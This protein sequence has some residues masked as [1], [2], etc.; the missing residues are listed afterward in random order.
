MAKLLQLR[1][2]TTAQHTSGGGFTGA[3][4][5]VT[6]D[7]TKDTLV[8]HD[9]STAGGHPIA[10]EI[11][12][13]TTVQHSS[14][15]GTVGE[16]TVD[17]DKD[18]LV[19]HD[20]ST[21]GGFPLA[22]FT[23]IT[24]HLAA[25][26]ITSI[27]YPT[28]DGQLATALA[29][30]G[31]DT[32]SETLIITGTGFSSTVT[33]TVEIAGSWYSLAGSTS[34]NG[35]KTVITCTNVTQ[36]AAGDNNVLRVANADGLKDETTVNFSADPLFT[37]AAALPAIQAG[38][39]LDLDLVATGDGTI[40]WTEGSPAMPAWMT[41]FTDGAT[42]TT[43]TLAGT[44][45]NTGGSETFSFNIK[46]QESGQNQVNNRTFSMLVF[47]YFATADG[48]GNNENYTGFRS[49]WWTTAGTHTDTLSIL[50]PV[51][52]DIL[53]VGGGGG[54]GGS[55]NYGGYGTAGGGGAG[56]YVATSSVVLAAGD[57]SVTIGAGGTAGGSQ[58]AGGTG[59]TSSFTYNSTTISAEGGGKA[60]GAGGGGAGENRT[61]ASGGGGTGYPTQ[62][63][64]TGGTHGNDGAK[65][66]NGGPGGGGGGSGDEANPSTGRT[67]HSQTGG[68][69]TANVWADGSSVTYSVGGNGGIRSSGGAGADGATAGTGGGGGQATTYDGGG[70]GATG[71]VIIRY[72]V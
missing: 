21:T 44:A 71:I 56:A 64:G 72:P 65:G 20:G 22:K 10:K 60:P 47:D 29:A 41:H 61:Q 26:I 39:T 67:E 12:Q 18:T 45:A 55:G 46:L 15:T 6:V 50:I 66:D 38:E 36:Q 17:T 8:V 40:T 11:Q 7:T 33:V 58:G 23:D 19:V 9:N 24:P 13:K 62:Y 48:N 3:E 51:T 30:T 16:V 2:G 31:S 68:I 69:G 28:E 54:G 27:T 52:C 35:A 4:G 1:R 57:Y 43:Q 25:P 42:G 5:E 14:F 37:T 34:V 32:V 49:H 59:G 70:A 63:G 53:V